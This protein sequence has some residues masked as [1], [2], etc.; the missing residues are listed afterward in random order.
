MAVCGYWSCETCSIHSTVFPSR[1]SAMAMWLKPVAAQAPCQCLTPGGIHTM[2]PGCIACGDCPHCWTQPAPEVTIN[3]CP[4]GCVCQAVRAPGSNV[5]VPPPTRPGDAAWKRESTRTVPVKFCFGP[6]LEG[7]ALACVT[8][9]SEADWAEACGPISSSVIA[10][11]V[12][13]FICVPR[14]SFR[15]VHGRSGATIVRGQ[16]SST[17]LQE[18]ARPEPGSWKPLSQ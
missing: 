15:P 7:W 4:S 14:C 11:S 9:T 10:M 17:L 12:S 5:T 8:F 13:D 1:A 2:S 3:V 6:I 16:S 18:D